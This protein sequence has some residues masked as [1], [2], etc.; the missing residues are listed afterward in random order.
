MR[1]R[2]TPPRPSKPETTAISA[3]RA[4]A[5]RDP[6]PDPR[7]LRATRAASTGRPGQSEVSFCI[8]AAGRVHEVRTTRRFPGDPEVDRICRETVEGWR[9]RPFLAG[10]KPHRTCSRVSFTIEFE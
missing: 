8:D 10:G 2:M 4:V 7:K 6:D 3:L 9:F 5:L 1:A